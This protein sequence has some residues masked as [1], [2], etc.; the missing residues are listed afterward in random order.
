MFL[1]AKG[2]FSE[3]ELTKVQLH[4]NKLGTKLILYWITSALKKSQKYSQTLVQNLWSI[5]RKLIFDFVTLEI[6]FC[7]FYWLKP[8]RE[9]VI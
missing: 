1:F 3:V 4:F 7:F 8:M 5:M 6:K 9:S 2:Y